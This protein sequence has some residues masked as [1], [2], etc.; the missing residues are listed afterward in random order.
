MIKHQL[1]GHTCNPPFPDICRASSFTSPSS[2]IEQLPGTNTL[3]WWDHFY[4]KKE[5]T[6]LS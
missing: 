4:C 5:Y 3:F 2:R 6:L 1:G